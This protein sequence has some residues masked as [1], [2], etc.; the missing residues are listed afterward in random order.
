VTTF[1]VKD[2][3]RRETSK[4][5]KYLRVHADGIG[6]A[7]V[8]DTDD[9]NLILTNEGATFRG[10]VKVTD[11]EKGW[12]ELSDVSLA[13]PEEAA[14]DGSG[15]TESGEKMSKQEWREKDEKEAVRRLYIS[16]LSNLTHLCEAG[17][18]TAIYEKLQR[19]A[20][21]YANQD[22]LWIRE[23]ATEY[24]EALRG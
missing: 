7:S 2:H 17:V 24:P 14:Q 8:W 20:R 13:S 3:E 12:K 11:T 4:G 9:A 16:H 23:D 10:E 15:A 1:T 5:K 18:G 21:R 19:D 6:W 22:L